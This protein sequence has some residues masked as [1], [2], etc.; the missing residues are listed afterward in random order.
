MGI[1]WIDIV[2]ALVFVVVIDCAYYGAAVNRFG[3]QGVKWVLIP[4]SGI[5]LQI[6]AMG[7]T[8]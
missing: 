1:D 7:W 6:L 4:L 5:C 2:L 8:R 3:P